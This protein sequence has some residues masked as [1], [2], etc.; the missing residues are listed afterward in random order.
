MSEVS[1]ICFGTLTSRPEMN[2]AEIAG[3]LPSFSV[4]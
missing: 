2:I 1:F 3:E 4:V